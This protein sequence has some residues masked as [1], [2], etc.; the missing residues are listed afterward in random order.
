MGS[1][2]PMGGGGGRGEPPLFVTGGEDVNMGCLIWFCS[3]LMG[4]LG[5][6]DGD[7]L[8]GCR[9]DKFSKFDR[10]RN[11]GDGVPCCCCCCCCVI[12]LMMMQHKLH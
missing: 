3:M 10:G 5:L 7:R 9:G 4:D 1:K 11:G 6:D 8:S 2:W 12:P